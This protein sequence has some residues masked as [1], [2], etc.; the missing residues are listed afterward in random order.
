MQQLTVATTS[1]GIACC[2]K[3]YTALF[4][5]DHIIHRSDGASGGATTFEKFARDHF[6][7]PVNASY[8]IPIIALGAD[9]A[10][11]MCSMVICAVVNGIVV[12]FEIPSVYVV[13]VAV[14]IVVNAII[15]D[16]SWI[17]PNI[18][19]QIRVHEIYALVNDANDD[20]ARS[21]KALG[22][23]FTC[24]TAILIGVGRCCVAVHTPKRTIRVVG[25]IR[26]AA[27]CQDVIW[28]NHPDIG[29]VAEQLQSPLDGLSFR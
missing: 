3:V 26:F 11:D 18:G 25:V 29:V 24:L 16:F 12:V 27:F 5:V 20:V 2:N 14:A 21:G 23:G 22:P 7:R 6:D 17:H 10:R 19:C 4:Q 1:P 15:G 9:S 8:T 28:L 13:D